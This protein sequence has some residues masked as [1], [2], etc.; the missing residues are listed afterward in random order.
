MEL[1]VASITGFL[2]YEITAGRVDF[3]RLNTQI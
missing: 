2:E 1:F 3:A